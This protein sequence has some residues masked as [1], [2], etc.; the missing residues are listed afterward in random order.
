MS[1][2]H[3]RTAETQLNAYIVDHGN[4][5]AATPGSARGAG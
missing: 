4:P 5:A 1:I 2:P 3:E